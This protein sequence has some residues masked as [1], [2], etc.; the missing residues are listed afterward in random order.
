[1]RAQDFK[2]RFR[3]LLDDRGW[4]QKEFSIISGITQAA[5]TRY[6]K[7]ERE[8]NVSNICRICEVTHTTPTW[9][10]GYG[11]NEPIERMD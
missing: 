8:P 10:L 6:L 4:T 3:L 2:S 1:M 11:P 9:L 5:V 7:G